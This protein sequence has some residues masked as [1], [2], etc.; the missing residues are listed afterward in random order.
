MGS[1]GSSELGGFRVFKVNPGSPASEGAL[2][3]FFDFVLEVNGQ[4]MTEDQR[5]FFE[6][7]QACENTATKLLVYNIRSQTV[8]DVYLTPR[9]WGG[10]GL[11]GATVRFDTIDNSENQGIRVL[12]VFP[13]SPAAHAGLMPYKDYMLG[14]SDVMFR[15][16]DELAELVTANLNKKLQ[17]YI[18]N[19]DS[20][21]IREVFLSPNTTWGGEGIIGCDIGSGMLHRIPAPR[22]PLAGALPPGPQPPGVAMPIQAPPIVPAVPPVAPADGQ[23]AQPG[24]AGAPPGQALWP[25]G[26]APPAPGAAAPLSTPG[27]VPGVQPSTLPYSPT[28]LQTQL[29]QAAELLQQQPGAGQN[30][31]L[32]SP[33][34]PVAGS[35]Q[36]F[37][38]AAQVDSPTV[39]TPGQ[40]LVPP[41]PPGTP[42]TPMTASNPA[43]GFTQPM[44]PMAPAAAMDGPGVIYE[45]S[46]AAPPPQA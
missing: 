15:D 4:K 14:T 17:M 19:A 41:A 40:G 2:E 6:K 27:A 39:G 46:A 26:T 28:A 30:L 5:S 3:V 12:E 10:V 16:M 9:Q 8:R 18:Y 11:L 22:R 23:P 32:P 38:A 7:I 35:A 31:T 1:G 21:T 43:G 33:A 36:S 34:T 37:I 42:C 29:T 20:E 24:A 44:Y 13:N 25:P 45:T